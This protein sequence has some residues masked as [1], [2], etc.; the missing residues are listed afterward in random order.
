[1]LHWLFVLSPQLSRVFYNTLK[2]T[3][4]LINIKEISSQLS[5]V[6]QFRKKFHHYADEFSI[7]PV[8]PFAVIMQKDSY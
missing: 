8:F 2:A 6:V 4:E 7:L 5:Y 3:R 1:M